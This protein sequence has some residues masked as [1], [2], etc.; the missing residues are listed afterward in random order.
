M[1][2]GWG[3]AMHGG[4]G[5]DCPR[6]L[7]LS[8]GLMKRTDIGLLYVFSDTIRCGKEV[9]DDKRGNPWHRLIVLS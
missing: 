7:K 3:V 8:M 6:G 2:G 4:Q 5:S 9:V 1:E